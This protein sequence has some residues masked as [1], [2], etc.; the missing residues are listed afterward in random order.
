MVLLFTEK[1]KKIAYFYA[2]FAFTTKDV[3]GNLK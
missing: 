3:E 2:F 1:S